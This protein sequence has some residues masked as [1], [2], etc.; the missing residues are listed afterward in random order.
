MA[1]EVLYRRSGVLVRRMMLEPGQASPW[2]RDVC[3]RVTVVLSGRRLA[4]EFLAGGP[5]HEAEVRAGQ[6]DWSAPSSQVHRAIN[7]GH[8][9]YEEV[10]TFFLGYRG[11]N[12]QP[13]WTLRTRRRRTR[14]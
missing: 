9:R 2:H 4:M 12:P 11:Q 1:Q 6:V 13:R 8:D 7:I 10:V 3:H 5:V 14:G